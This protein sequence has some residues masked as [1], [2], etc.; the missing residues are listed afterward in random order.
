[1]DIA[2][3]MKNSMDGIQ[4]LVNH[5]KEIKTVQQLVDLCE[6]KGMVTPL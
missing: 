4:A 5:L 2:V 1:M 3:S 6:K